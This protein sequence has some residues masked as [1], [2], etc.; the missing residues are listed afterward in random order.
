MSHRFL[1][2]LVGML[3]VKELIGD[4]VEFV[5]DTLHQWTMDKTSF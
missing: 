2:V 3:Y 5:I 4:L 1:E